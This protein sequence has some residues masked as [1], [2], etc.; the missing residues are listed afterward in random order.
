LPELD[1]GESIDALIAGQIDVAMIPAHAARAQRPQG[2]ID[3][4]GASGSHRQDGARREA[5]GVMASFRIRTLTCWTCATD[6]WY[7][8]IYILPCIHGV[9]GPF[10]RLG[11]FP[12]EQS[13]DLPPSPTAQAFYRSCPT[14]WQRYTSFWLTSLLKRIV[15]FVIPVAAALISVIGFPALLQ[16]AAHSPYRPIAPRSRKLGARAR[17]KHRRIAIPRV[18]DADRRNRTRRTRGPNPRL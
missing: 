8:R 3:E 7:E 4:R 11:E 12:A 16:V 6:C 13:N 18:S 14:F 9:A 2:R 17:S 10:N 5:S 15:F 1:Y